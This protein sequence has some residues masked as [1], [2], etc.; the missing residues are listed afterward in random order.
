MCP[1]SSWG[2]KIEIVVQ[3]CQLE[4]LCQT[5]LVLEEKKRKL[6]LLLNFSSLLLLFFGCCTFLHKCIFTR[7]NIKSESVTLWKSKRSI[8][9]WTQKERGE[10]WSSVYFF[11]QRGRK[12]KQAAQAALSSPFVKLFMTV[13]TVS[14]HI[15]SHC[16]Q[17]WIHLF[18]ADPVMNSCTVEYVAYE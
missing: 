18:C 1:L 13:I 7:R 6:K 14:D 2:V 15:C 9:N 4:S 17:L 5:D 16:G 3:I 10:E 11:I 12:N 8:P